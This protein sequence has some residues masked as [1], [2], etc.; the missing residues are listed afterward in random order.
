MLQLFIVIL[1]ADGS[2]LGAAITCGSMALVDAAVDMIDVVVASTVC[3]LGPHIALDPTQEE[4]TC[5][6]AIVTMAY[7]PSLAEV[8]YVAQ[9]GKTKYETVQALMELAIDGCAGPIF[10]LVLIPFQNAVKEMKIPI[11]K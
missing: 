5:A 8:T 7:M 1:D 11:M 9:T 4:Q 3:T 2:E 10:Q 6:D